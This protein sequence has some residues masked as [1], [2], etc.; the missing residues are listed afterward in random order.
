MV[1]DT[2]K[3]TLTVDGMPVNLT[4][5]EFRLLTHLGMHAPEVISAA[6]LMDHLYG[7]DHDKDTNVLEALIVRLRRKIGIDSIA[8]RKGVGYFLQ[9][10]ECSTE[11]RSAS[12]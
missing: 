7:S 5:L 9:V 2:R 1:I 4:P 8:N 12:G 6:D 3:K 11:N 10:T